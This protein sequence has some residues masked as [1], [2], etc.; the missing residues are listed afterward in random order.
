MQEARDG[1]GAAQQCDQSDGRTFEN[2][3]HFFAGQV[4][5]QSGLQND[6]NQ[7]NGS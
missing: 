7:S 6:E 3:R 4:Q 2:E 1:C 5:F